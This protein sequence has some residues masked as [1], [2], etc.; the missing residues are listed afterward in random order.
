[1]E[2]HLSRRTELVVQS[3]IRNMSIECD[4]VKGINLSQGICDLPVPSEVII[5]AQ[6]AMDNGI[7]AYTRYDGLDILREAIAQKQQAFTGMSL[8]SNA[9]IVVS[10]GATGALYCS[11]LAMLNPGDEVL[12]F[13]PFYGYHVSTLQAANLVPVF[14]RSTPPDW[15][16]RL[17]DLEAAITENTRG[18]VI[19]SPANPSG[20]VYSK[21]ELLLIANFARN[22]NLVVFT[23][24]IYEHFIYDDLEHI[25]MAT[26]PD[27]WER[28]ISISGLSKT[29]SITGW[30]LGYCICDE[31]WSRAI[32]YFNDLIYVCAPAPLQVGVAE[33]LKRLGK[34]YY[35]GLSSTFQFRR[36]MICNALSRAGFRPFVPQGSYYVLADISELDGADSKE[37][38]MHLLATT[39][40][41]C[42]PGE[43]FYHDNA[44][45]NLA[46][47]CFAKKQSVLAEACDR[48]IR[49]QTG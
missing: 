4:K 47:F 14:V 45:Q 1:M 28:T 15:M 26:L 41:G 29:F 25:P 36:D 34:D 20:K 46:R 48:L 35:E 21:S 12:L 7:N 3:E 19:C 33:G 16:P 40:V 10:A 5:A 9:E 32:G 22:H 13:E 39:G 38:A 31:K 49:Y 11:C 6:Q 27:M 24:E 2:L 18:L 43:A 37:K 23:D 8:N 30:R 42:V 44:G 17:D